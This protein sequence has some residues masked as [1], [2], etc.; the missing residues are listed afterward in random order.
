MKEHKQG[1]GDYLSA[2]TI[3]GRIMLLVPIIIG[4]IVFISAF[5]WQGETAYEPSVEGSTT[6]TILQRNKVA[7]T[8]MPGGTMVFLCGV[9][10]LIYVAVKRFR[11][12]LR[13]EEE[14]K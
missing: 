4:V 2:L 9:A 13:G 1:A 8:L 3:M 12:G 14:G 5:F 7:E 11:Q 10:T 6:V